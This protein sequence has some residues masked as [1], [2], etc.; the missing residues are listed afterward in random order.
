MVPLCMWRPKKGFLRALLSIWQAKLVFPACKTLIGG[1][2]LG[3]TQLGQQQVLPKA[4]D[5]G[6]VERGN[7]GINGLLEVVADKECQEEDHLAPAPA[8]MEETTSVRT[9]DRVGPDV[10]KHLENVCVAGSKTKVLFQGNHRQGGK[11]S[12]E[13][14]G[15]RKKESMKSGRDARV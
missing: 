3:N 12:L 6:S 10:I 4:D 14:D 9:A 5:K 1:P 11:A 8:V 15:R 7:I 2:I 13:G